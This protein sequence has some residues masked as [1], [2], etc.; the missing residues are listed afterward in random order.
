MNMETEQDKTLKGL[1]IAIQMEIDGKEYYQKA[2]QSSH[3]QLGSK[4]FESLAAEEDIHRRRFEE[5]YDAMRNKKGWP[6]VDFQPDMGRTLKTVFAQAIEQMGS[7]IRAQ[8]TELEAVKTSMDMENKTY[9]FYKSRIKNTNYDA[10]IEYYE[11]LAT[12]ERTHYLI[13]LDYYEYLKDPAG[14][15]V[16]KERHSLDGG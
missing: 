4:L 9:D 10:E 16:E 3:N 14:W 8:D 6:K 13:L 2:S 12:Q 1:Q 15:F 11:A 5:I 7:N